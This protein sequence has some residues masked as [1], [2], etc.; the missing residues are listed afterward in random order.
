MAGDEA[1][2]K[3]DALQAYAAHYHGNVQK[4]MGNSTVT[5][6][7]LAV[8]LDEITG[9]FKSTGIGIRKNSVGQSLPEHRGWE[10]HG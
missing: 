3:L 5:H 6:A 2:E 4:G 8:I 10:R 7:E 1:N 9:L